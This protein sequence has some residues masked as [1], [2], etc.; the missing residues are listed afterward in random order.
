MQELR[1]NTIQYNL[2]TPKRFDP[3]ERYPLII[4]IH[5]AGGRGNDL[6][7]VRY[8]YMMESYIHEKDLD[9]MVA[10]PLCEF[11]NWYMCF[12]ELI[13][14]VRFAARM[15]NVDPDR[16]YLMGSSMGGYATWSLL[17]CVP[18]LIAAAVPIC[19]GGMPW[20]AVRM[21]NVPL[22]VFHGVDDSAV[23]FTESVKMVNAVRAVGGRVE[24]VLLPGWGHN[25][26]EPALY[27]YGSVEWLMA[28]R[29]SEKGSV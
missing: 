15:D 27:T 4:Y 12:S 9:V 5:G 7:N 10:A 11:D 18:E 2:A 6:Q 17:L 13:E 26:W 8:P 24:F 14:F 19:G 1:H 22:R 28:H 3:A 29:L 21:K 25:V 23:D 20:D 16:V